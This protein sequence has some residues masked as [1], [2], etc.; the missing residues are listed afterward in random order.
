MENDEYKERHH[1]A[2][3]IWLAL[4]FILAGGGL[5]LRQMGFPLPYWLFTWQMLLIVLGVGMGFANGFRGPA[6]AILILVGGFFLLEDLVPRFTYRQYLWPLGII[7]VGF[8][9]LISPSRRR[10]WRWEEKWRH[11]ERWRDSFNPAKS[12]TQEGES[13]SEDYFHSHSIFGGTKRVV[14]SKNFKGGTISCVMGACELDLRQADFEKQAIIEVSQTFGG[15]TII[16]P[17]HWQVKVDVNSI[18]AGV[19]DE[20]Q[21]PLSAL[22]DKLLIIRGTSVFG[23]LEIKNF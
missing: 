14:L 21:P 5:F 2:G 6:W 17:P 12:T 15:C 9:L 10:N 19:D 23:G 4:A 1:G 13:F 20:R 18:F 8:I 22:S 11:R 3:R 7:A 16:V